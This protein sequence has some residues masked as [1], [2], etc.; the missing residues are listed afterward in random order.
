MS[1]L[2]N[3]REEMRRYKAEELAR[4][5]DLGLLPKPRKVPRVS[6][7]QIIRTSRIGALK[8][9]VIARIARHLKAPRRSNRVG[10]SFDD[11]QQLMPETFSDLELRTRQYIPIFREDGW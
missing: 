1:T 8:E 9:Y 4:R 3:L 10:A 11:L 6:S 7:H 2:R 5:N